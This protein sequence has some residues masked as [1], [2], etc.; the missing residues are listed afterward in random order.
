MVS[1]KFRN[2][3]LFND[4]WIYRA[5]RYL[6][7]SEKMDCVTIF[8]VVYWMFDAIL[9]HCYH[10]LRQGTVLAVGS[11]SHGFVTTERRGKSLS[12]LV[13][14]P[15]APGARPASIVWQRGSIWAMPKAGINVGRSW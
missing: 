6:V 5:I 12:K 8:D 14:K 3:V 13:N 9:V 15:F 7:L 11:L 1:L 10:K 4:N 2:S